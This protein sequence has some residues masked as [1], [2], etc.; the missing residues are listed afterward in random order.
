MEAVI[1]QDPLQMILSQ[2]LYADLCIRFPE[3]KEGLVQVQR[4]G[5]SCYKDHF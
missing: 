1:S 5:I 2:T 4:I 3:I